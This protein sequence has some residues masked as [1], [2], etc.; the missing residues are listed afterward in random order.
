MDTIKFS[1]WQKLDL[2]VGK[3]LNAEEVEGAD[4]LYKLEIDLG[5]EKRTLVAGIKPFYPK[6][7]LKGKRCVV[8]ANLEPRTI[9]GIESKG[10]ILAATNSDISEVKLLQP[11]EDIESG[12]KVS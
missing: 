4:R 6:E 12:S 2:R 3:I 9:R 1:D 11:D 5:S 8:F 10:M 7:K